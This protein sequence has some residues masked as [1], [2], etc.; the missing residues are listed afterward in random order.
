MLLCY[1][2]CLEQQLIIYSTFLNLFFSLYQWT[3]TGK[4]TVAS[5]YDSVIW[6]VFN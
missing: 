2:C 3:F 1:L 6:Y 5:Q 4:N